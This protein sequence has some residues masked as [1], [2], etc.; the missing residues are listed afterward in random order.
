MAPTRA[1]TSESPAEL[2]KPA[3]TS[4]SPRA[5]TLLHVNSPLF[6]KN[7]EPTAS[8]VG[9]A[10]K[11]STYAA[12]GVSPSHAHENDRRA[13]A[14]RAGAADSIVADAEAVREA[15]GSTTWW[16]LGQSF[17]GFILTHYLAAAPASL[18]GVMIA[19]G[20]PPLVGAEG[21]TASADDVYAETYPLVDEG[22]SYAS[23]TNDEWLSGQG[24]LELLHDGG[25]APLRRRATD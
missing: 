11:S 16:A 21:A 2:A 14:G 6:V 5:A 9:N 23:D 17:G 12:N 13:L 22:F 25:P 1:V 20:L 24:L 15:L 3:S 19:A 7:P 10:R 18:A 8:T 4:G